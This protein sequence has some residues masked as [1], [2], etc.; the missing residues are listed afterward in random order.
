MTIGKIS[1]HCISLPCGK[2]VRIQSYSGTDFPAFGLNVIP[3]MGTL[4]AVLNS[5][6]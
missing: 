4:Y 1:P 6:F 3:N 5:F 2:S